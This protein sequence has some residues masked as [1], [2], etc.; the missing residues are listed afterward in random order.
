MF[1]LCGLNAAGLAKPPLSLPPRQAPNTAPV[2][3]QLR[4]D[5]FIASPCFYVNHVVTKSNEKAAGSII[6][7]SSRSAGEMYDYR[8]VQLNF[9]K[10]WENIESESY[11][12]L[13]R[14]VVYEGH[15]ILRDEAN[16]PYVNCR[17]L[18]SPLLSPMLAWQS[19]RTGDEE[20]W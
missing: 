19:L 15:F 6:V 20:E 1:L 13:W 10:R 17:S 3:I 9:F 8:N 7:C 14:D 4:F 16:R 2:M 12:A 5:E 11:V 18:L